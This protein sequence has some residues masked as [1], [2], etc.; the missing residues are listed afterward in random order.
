MAKGSRR[1]RRD[2]WGSITEVERGRRYVIRYWASTD[3][4]GY[5]RHSVTVRGTRA[6]AEKKRAELMLDHSGDAPCPTIG[7]VWTKWYLPTMERRVEE[8]DLAESTLKQMRSCWSLHINPRWSDV[9]CNEVK[10]LQVQQWLD[11]MDYG[12]ARISLAALKP[13]LDYPVRYGQI[14]SNPF[15]EKYIMPS[16]RTVSRRDDGIWTLDELGKAWSAIYGKWFEA[17]FLFAGFGGMRVGEA[18]GVMGSDVTSLDMDDQTLAVVRVE[19]QI[20]NRGNTPTTR[21]KTPH[22]HR[23]VVIPGRTGKRILDLAA[24]NSGYLS[25]DGLG[26]PNTQSRLN[27]SWND[28]GMA[29]PFRNLRNSWQTWMR[30]EMKVPPHYIEPMMGH[31]V[32]GVTGAY[33]DRP[34]VQMFANVVAEAYRL[35]PFDTSWELARTSSSS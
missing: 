3:E 18:L 28:A 34:Q 21:L 17:A 15:R 25:G 22:S 20:P 19:R 1:R 10:P 12:P 30:W 33:Y 32:D 2:A 6:D 9:A 27:I 26:G 14:Q 5:R 4:R 23:F 7:Q 11:D 35:R 13:M 8:G 16:K 31:K 29:H 24:E